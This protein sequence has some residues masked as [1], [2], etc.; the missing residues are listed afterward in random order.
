[1]FLEKWHTHPTPHYP[2]CFL[3][4]TVKVRPCW[5]SCILQEGR[6]AHP[7]KPCCQRPGQGCFS[8]FH[9]K[10]RSFRGRT[11]RNCSPR[12][13][14]KQARQLLSEQRPPKPLK[15]KLKTNKEDSGLFFFLFFIQCAVW[16]GPQLL[17]HLLVAD[18]RCWGASSSKCKRRLALPISTASLNSL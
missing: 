17:P 8:E 9:T 16:P 3:I 13:W 6:L 11:Q 2:L 18:G 14:R 5:S 4:S 12:A 15:K 10:P 7:R 1:M